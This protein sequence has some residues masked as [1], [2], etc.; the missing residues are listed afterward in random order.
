VDT[1]E[2]LIF[3]DSWISKT[4]QKP[5][6]INVAG[7]T[8]S[9]KSYFCHILQQYLKQGSV[10][11]SLD[12]Y[13]RDI[14][15]PYLPRDFDHHP[16]FDEPNSYHT[17]EIIEAVELL[18]REV[19]IL[20]PVYS[21]ET[22]LRTQSSKVVNPAPIIIIDGLF[23]I[24]TLHKQMPNLNVYLE[25]EEE[26]CL[27]RRIERDATRFGISP[28]AIRRHYETRIKPRQIMYVEPQRHLADLIINS[29]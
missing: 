24:R 17:E 3:I 2:A 26:L 8:C 18:I 19:P 9:G 25:T 29:S 7:G 21:I 12:D 15:D 16:I 22:N 20:V 14:T 4:P 27:Q 13:F 23:A 6:L 28:Q 11:L 1:K 10:I 5:C